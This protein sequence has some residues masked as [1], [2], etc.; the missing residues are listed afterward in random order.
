[1]YAFI[2]H[3][4]ATFPSQEP[5]IDNAPLARR[6]RRRTSPHELNILNKE[7]KLGSTPNKA[8]RVEIA[9]VVHMTEKAVQIWFQN[10]RQAL[11][12]QSNVEKEVLELPLTDVPIHQQHEQQ[13]Q[14]S[15]HLTAA[16]PPPPPPPQ[17]HAP[18]Y[19]LPAQAQAPSPQHVPPIVSSTPTKPAKSN[20]S[21][22]IQ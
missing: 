7:F 22:L 3:S 19:P 8:R 10:K 2:S 17:P 12:K 6:K 18:M 9:K 21:I 20:L 13:L 15:G 4:P 16:A 1:L 11:R 5:D 14:Q